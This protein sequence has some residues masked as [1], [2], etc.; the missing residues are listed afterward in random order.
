[1]E[2][3]VQDKQGKY[4]FF[5]GINGKDTHYLYF[6]CVFIITILENV[7]GTLISLNIHSL[8]AAL[9]RMKNSAPTEIPLRRRR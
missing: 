3:A 1:L 5:S 8:N 6:H 9:N 2:G 4:R 7:I